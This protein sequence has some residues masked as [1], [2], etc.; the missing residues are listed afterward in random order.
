[1][2][3]NFHPQYLDS[4]IVD[5]AMEVGNEIHVFFHNL[6]NCE[7]HTT[8]LGSSREEEGRRFLVMAPGLHCFLCKFVFVVLNK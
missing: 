1:M 4:V 2:K 6:T 7:A 3:T 8:H 5:D